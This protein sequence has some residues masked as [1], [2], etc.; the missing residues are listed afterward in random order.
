[1]LLISS[2]PAALDFEDNRFASGSAVLPG[3]SLFAGAGTKA[4]RTGIRM[5]L[6]NCGTM[7]LRCGVSCMMSVIQLMFSQTHCMPMG[8]AFSLKCTFAA[9]LLA[10][11]QLLRVMM[12][13]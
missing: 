10:G 4:K 12:R 7:L 5:L 6:I 9:V 2:S 1:M 8:H 13:L 3:C 11:L